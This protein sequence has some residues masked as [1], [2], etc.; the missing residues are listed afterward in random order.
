M[1]VAPFLICYYRHI[2]HSTRPYL[3]TWWLCS[4]NDISSGLTWSNN[5]RSFYFVTLQGYHAQNCCV[6]LLPHCHDPVAQ[7]VGKVFLIHKQVSEKTTGPILAEIHKQDVVW[8]GHGLITF[9]P[10]CC[11]FCCYC[12]NFKLLAVCCRLVNRF[13]G[14]L[15][16]QF[17]W[18]STVRCSSHG[19]QTLSCLCMPSHH[20]F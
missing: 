10:L 2:T 8:D 16:E 9:W 14:K 7:F 19:L 1:N 15:M 18:N 20:P 11:N 12:G 17:C 3:I 6:K 5:S 4:C 13:Q